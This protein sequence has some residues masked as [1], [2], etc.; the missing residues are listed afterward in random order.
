MAL[1]I[2][3]SALM[4][5]AVC[6]STLYQSYHQTSLSAVDNAKNVTLVAQRAISRNLEILSLSLDTLTYRYQHPLPVRDLSENQRQAYLFGGTANARHISVMAILDADG[7]VKASS[8]RRSDETSP[9]YADRAYFT[10]HRDSPGVGLYVSR[11]ISA[12]LGNELKVVVLS[13]RLARPDGSFDGVV[14]MALDLAYFRELFAGLALGPDGVISLYSDDGVAYMR[15]PYRE[16]VIGSDLSASDNYQRLKSMLSKD[17]GSFFSHSRHDGIKRLYTFRR[18]PNT[19]LLVFVGYAE[20]AIFKD[21]YEALYSVLLSLAAFTVVCAVL[22]SSIR[23]EFRKRVSVETQL[24]ALVRTD[25]LTGLL[26]RRALDEL[27]HATWERCQRNVTSTFSLLFIDVDY[28]KTYNDTYGH[29]SGDKALQEVARAIR[30][31]LPR[32]T[33]CAARYGGEEFVVLLDETTEDGA[34]LVA[35]RLC[36]AIRA[37]RIE[38]QSSSLQTLTASIGVSGYRRDRHRRIEDVVNA[39]DE[40]LYRAKHSGR[41]CAHL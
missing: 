11:P 26:N 40:A 7:K 41:N 1:V 20:S 39:A 13:K 25:G 5:V 32:N 2:G 12:S 30:D 35:I 22:M 18:V 36:D 10:V 15:I 16:S 14:V 24:N 3:I 23:Q 38:H 4:V 37:S 27:L 31:N 33:D 19:S 28:F 17:D 8:R 29:K 21:W 6:G 9:V 34:M